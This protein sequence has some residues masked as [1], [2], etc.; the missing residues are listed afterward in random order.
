MADG[1]LLIILHPAAQ[2]PQSTGANCGMF[3]IY[4]LF[5]G[6]STT[7]RFGFWVVP[8]RLCSCGKKAW[9]R[10]R[11]CMSKDDFPHGQRQGIEHNKKTA[12][13]LGG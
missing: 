9:S 13:S 8:F 4:H 11:S 10:P 1:W 7:N 3:A 12:Y 5:G 6:T 2:N